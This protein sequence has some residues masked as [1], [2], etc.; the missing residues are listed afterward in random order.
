[1]SRACYIAVAQ[2]RRL[3][4]LAKEFGDCRLFFIP[5]SSCCM[6]TYIHV[7][8][9]VLG[10]KF[11]YI[12]IEIVS[13]NY[14]WTAGNGCGGGGTYSVKGALDVIR[15]GDCRRLCLYAAVFTL[16]QLSQACNISLDR[17]FSRGQV[18]V[19]SVDAA[20]RSTLVCPVK[21]SYSR[22]KCRCT[23]W[24]RTRHI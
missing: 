15:E 21:H 19:W 17:C 14:T 4:S 11:S 20:V 16:V 24:K 3:Q 5:S 23:E 9:T 2:G 22:G 10:F 12:C 13:D 18:G 8:I 1:M 7:Y 6:C